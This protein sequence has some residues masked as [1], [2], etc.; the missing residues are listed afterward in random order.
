MFQIEF[1]RNP[2]AE[3]D[4]YKWL[5]EILDKELPKLK[6]QIPQEAKQF[7]LITNRPLARIGGWQRFAILKKEDDNLNFSQY[8]K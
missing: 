2:K 8:S 1:V 7:V 6:R 4:P 5:I 3:S